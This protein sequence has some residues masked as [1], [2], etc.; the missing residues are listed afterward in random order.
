M[1]IAI[2]GS[3]NYPKLDIVD[4]HVRIL[5]PEAT[6]VS[7]GAAGVDITAE[8][9]AKSVG[10]KTIVYLPDWSQGKGAGFARNSLIVEAADVI[11]GFWDGASRGVIDTLK[12]AKKADKPYQIYGPSGERL[13]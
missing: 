7:G 9:A 10:M 4:A 2:V 8:N 11:I 5:D 12:K 1:K 13:R 3:R 6:I